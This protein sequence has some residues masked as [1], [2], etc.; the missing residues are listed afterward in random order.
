MNTRRNSDIDCNQNFTLPIFWPLC[1][2]KLRNSQ[3]D[4][5]DDDVDEV[6][7]GSSAV[8]KV[9]ESGRS[10]P[11]KRPSLP[12]PPPSHKV[13]NIPEVIRLVQELRRSLNQRHSNKLRLELDASTK[14]LKELV[15]NQR[16]KTY[17]IT[18]V[19]LELIFFFGAGVSAD[20]ELLE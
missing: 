18:L 7:L 6:C 12:L 13:N 20:L 1:V 9:V 4:D 5:V 14:K 2:S 10:K 15:A 11:V 19:E 3:H 8:L 17:R 16:Y